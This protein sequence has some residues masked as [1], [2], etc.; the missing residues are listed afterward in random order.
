MIEGGVVST[1]TVVAIF[2]SNIPEGLSSSAGLKTMGW[3]A[4]RVFILWIGVTLCTGFSSLAGYSI[5]G[6]FDPA[7]ISIVLSLSAGG[8]LA[9]LV[10]TMRL[11][12]PTTTSRVMYSTTAA[13]INP[14]TGCTDA[15][16]NLSST[17]GCLCSIF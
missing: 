4:K 8:I 2:L 3:N 13:M 10:D 6:Q 14:K 7:V 9:M 5:F 1:A 16:S 15:S 12:S 11:L 17:V